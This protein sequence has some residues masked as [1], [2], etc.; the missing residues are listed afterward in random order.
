MI[1]AVRPVFVL[2]LLVF[3]DGTEPSYPGRT[4][5]SHVVGVNRVDVLFTVS[6]RRAASSPTLAN[7][8]SKCSR[9]KKPQT[10]LEFGLSRTCRCVW[11]F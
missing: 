2:A 9:N 7:L 3:T 1:K 11:R 8:I 6:I 5:H 10:V 4:R